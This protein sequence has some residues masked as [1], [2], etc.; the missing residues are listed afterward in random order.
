M[1]CVWIQSHILPEGHESTM[2]VSETRNK[3]QIYKAIVDAVLAIV[4]VAVAVARDIGLWDERDI[5]RRGCSVF[6]PVVSLPLLSLHLSPGSLSPCRTFLTSYFLFAFFALTSA[7][8][9][10]VSRDLCFIFLCM[11]VTTDCY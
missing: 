10:S 7:L 11:S 4:F 1:G 3:Q 8:A 6:L 5:R 2:T 9:V